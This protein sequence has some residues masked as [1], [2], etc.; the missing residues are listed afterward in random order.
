[1]AQN[2]LLKQVKSHPKDYRAYHLLAYLYGRGATVSRT[3]LRECE[4]EPTQLSVLTSGARKQA[5]WLLMRRLPAGLGW[6]QLVLVIAA[7]T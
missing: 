1:M 5:P 4:A 3:L 7:A 2:F 6:G